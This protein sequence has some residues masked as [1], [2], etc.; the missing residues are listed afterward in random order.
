MTGPVT[1]VFKGSFN[2][3]QLVAS[4]PHFEQAND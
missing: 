2:I 4:L 3:D 1:T